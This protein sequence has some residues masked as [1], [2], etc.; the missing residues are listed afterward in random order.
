MSVA[1]SRRKPEEPE[2]PRHPDPPFTLSVMAGEPGEPE[3][4]F[5]T[6]RPLQPVQHAAPDGEQDD[7]VIEPTAVYK[8]WLPS[9]DWDNV[10]ITVEYHD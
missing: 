8:P 5:L 6:S 2:E 4:V 3:R 10:E 7:D 9:T 1:W